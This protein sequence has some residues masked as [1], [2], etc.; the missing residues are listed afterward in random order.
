MKAIS[1]QFQALMRHHLN[2]EWKPKTLDEKQRKSPL[3]VVFRLFELYPL[4][5][6]MRLAGMKRLYWNIHRRTYMALHHGENL[7]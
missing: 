7:F 1:L 6:A 3:G 4:Y 5:L 2:P